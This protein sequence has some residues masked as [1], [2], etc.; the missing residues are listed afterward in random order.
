MFIKTKWLILIKKRKQHQ[1]AFKIKVANSVITRG[2][3]IY[4]ASQLY[5]VTT[6]MVRDWIRHKDQLEQLSWPRRRFGAEYPKR[7]KWPELEEQLVD[8]IEQ[9][10]ARECVIT[11]KSIRNKAI[12]ISRRIYDNTTFLASQGWFENFKRR[13]KLSFRR[14]SSSGRELGASSLDSIV[15]FIKE[16][17]SINS[18]RTRANIFNMDE[19]SIYLDFPSTY[20][21][22]KRGT[23]RAKRMK[24]PH[25]VTSKPA[26]LQRFAHIGKDNQPTVPNCPFLLSCL[27]KHR[28]RLVIPHRP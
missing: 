22:A 25:P 9:E 28:S 15:K 24:R 7:S 23:K 16:N 14:I 27:E 17:E 1:V 12:D 21:Y 18:S 19:T 13:K 10:R 2:K 4:A 26:S 20:T 11:S 5:G 8:W 3:S 6:K